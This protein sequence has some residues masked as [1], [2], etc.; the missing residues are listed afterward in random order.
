MTNTEFIATMRLLN[1]D[2]APDG[3]PAV[4]MSDINRLCDIIGLVPALDLLQTR[5]RQGA[6]IEFQ[7]G[8]WWL[9]EKD[10]GPFVCSGNTVR[11]LLVNHLAGLLRD[12]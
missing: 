3:Y 11:D 5:L 7:D 2:H 6:R 1:A 8:K 12:P 10:A 9:F 4:K